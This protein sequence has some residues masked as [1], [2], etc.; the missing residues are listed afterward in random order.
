MALPFAGFYFSI[1]GRCLRSARMAHSLLFGVVQ[2]AFEMADLAPA[3]QLPGAQ[4]VEETID[5]GVVQR[6]VARCVQ[7]HRP[8]VAVE[9]REHAAVSDRRQRQSGMASRKLSD[10]GNAA[11]EPLAHALPL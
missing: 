1:A 7:R 10:A 6:E 4:P 3:L 5:A 9:H 11:L 8:R 2:R